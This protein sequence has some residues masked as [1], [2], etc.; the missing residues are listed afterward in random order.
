VKKNQL[1][2]VDPLKALKPK[3]INKLIEKVED[4]QKSQDENNTLKVYTD[5]EK[6]ASNPALY[7]TPESL[8][9]EEV[10]AA[11]RQDIIAELD[12]VNLYEAHKNATNNKELKGILQHIIEEEKEHS[13]ELQAFLNRN[14]PKQKEAF[15]KEILKKAMKKAMMKK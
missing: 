15:E 7:K 14:D 6:S 8:T 9:P 4:F 13:A 2:L 12:A 5:L 10:L 11:V 3:D 1:E